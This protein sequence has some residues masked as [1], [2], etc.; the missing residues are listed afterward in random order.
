MLRV[1]LRSFWEHKRRLISTIV[2]IVLGVAFMAGTFVLSDTLDKVFDDLFAE[3]SEEIDTLVQGEVL[4]SDPFAGDQRA[5]LDPGLVD[6]VA[7]STPR[8]S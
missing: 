7:A 2:A 5:L 6:T 3:S 1:T 8:R 4:F